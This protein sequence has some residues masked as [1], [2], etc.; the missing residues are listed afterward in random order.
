MQ[1]AATS[2]VQHGISYRTDQENTEIEPSRY[3]TPS[4]MLNRQLDLR[5]VGQ[6]HEIAIA[7]DDGPLDNTKLTQLRR[8]FEEHYQRIYELTMPEVEVECVSLSVRVASPVSS[9]SIDNVTSVNQSDNPGQPTL[10][11]ELPNPNK[12]VLSQGNR[13]VY[14]APTSRLIDYA[15]YAR[16]SLASGYSFTGP[17]LVEEDETCTVVPTGFTATVKPDYSLVLEWHR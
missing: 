15:V 7:L 10:N 16:S 14:D 3:G 13:D 9:A 1:E 12:A 17:A 11:H 5:Y 6:G 8:L 4:L 2:I